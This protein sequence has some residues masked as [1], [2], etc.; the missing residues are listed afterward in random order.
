[1]PLQSAPKRAI[2]SWLLSVALHT[3]IFLACGLWFAWQPSLRQVATTER[4]AQIVLVPASTPNQP[5]AWLHETTSNA[6]SSASANEQRRHQESL[7][8]SDDSSSLDPLNGAS[9]PVALAG[10]ELPQ[11]A[12][13][14]PHGDGLVATPGNLSGQGKP[15]ILPGLDEAAILAEE[16]A[17]PRES[18][19]TGPQ[20]TMSLFGSNATGRSFVFVIDRSES[21][22]SSGL[23]VIETAAKEL[24]R[25]L[26]ALSPEQTFQVVAYNQAATQFAKRE[27]MPA[28]SERKEE[29]IRFVKNLSAFGGT[30]HTYGLQAALRLKPEVIYLLTDGGD[31]IPDALK[32]RTLRD[33]SAGGTQ[34]HC[35]HFGRGEPRP[36]SEAFLQRVAREN[37]GS[38]VYVDL[39]RR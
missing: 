29:L 8:G 32:L 23:G 4:R 36:E 25:S 7:A 9:P 15:K 13:S 12:G 5:A 16:A 31:P 22:G 2:P 38:Y 30:E 24:A 35:L 1:M 34:I 14:L 3:A 27:L 18:L 33:L 6:S 10:V 11:L 19:P 26:D 20:A 21:M 37:R 39:N 28:S 17:R